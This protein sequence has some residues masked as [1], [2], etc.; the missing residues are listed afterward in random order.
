MWKIVILFIFLYSPMHAQS[1]S[2]ETYLSHAQQGDAASM[3]YVGTCLI[4]GRGVAKDEKQ[5]FEWCYKA[6]Q[7]DNIDGM[8]QVGWCYTSGTGV[9]KNKKL[10]FEYSLKAAQKGQ[11]VAQYNT[12]INYF[13]GNG[14]EINEQLGFEWCLKSA[15]N[16]YAVAE[17]HIGYCYTTGTGVAKDEKQ[18]F[19]WFV[20]ASKHGD[21]VA[22]YNLARIYNAGTLVEL[23]TEVAFNWFLKSAEQ[24]YA[25]SQGQVGY[26]YYNGI[27]VPKNLDEAFKWFMKAS[28]NGNVQAMKSLGAC[29]Y[30]GEGVA[31]N[32]E[33]GFRWYLEAANMGD[34]EAMGAVCRCYLNGDGVSKN[35]QKGFEWGLKAAEGSCAFA[36]FIVGNCY[37]D[38]QGTQQDYKKAFYWYEKAAEQNLLDA[39]NALAY[40]YIQGSGINKDEAKA[41]EMINK[42]IELDPNNLN[43]K[44]TKGELYSIVG[45]KEKALAMLDE[46][47]KT[48]PSF[49]K[50]ANSQLYQYA[51][52]VR[53]V[54]NVDID[55]PE[56]DTKAPNTFAVIIAN[57][58][59]K[60]VASVPFALND[61]E[62][63]AEYCQKTLGISEQNIHL[64]KDATLND[65]KFNI[66]WLQNVLKAYNGEASVIFYYAGHGIPDEQSKTAFILPVDGY[67][68]DVS[69]GYSLIDLYKAL[70]E[71]PSKKISVF[72]DACFSGVKRDGGM[73]ASAR[74]V[75]IKVKKT[76]PKGNMV[77]FSAA[78]NDETAYPYKEQKHGLFTYNLLKK[79]QETKGEVTLGDLSDF[80]KKQVER[81]SVVTNG[82]LQSPSVIGSSVG[83]DDWRL[84]KLK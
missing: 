57:E 19:D 60:R 45:E 25:L 81:Q 34:Y 54:N 50:N 62:I 18:G 48:D 42:A 29:Y 2:F 77:I 84:W 71:L 35:E 56:T 67:G 41:F 72:L 33:E 74:G 40:F 65:L 21:E 58:N 30:N 49:F 51:K 13:Y 12:G 8:T 1:Q 31:V 76:Q 22:Q 27:G 15:M 26:R 10:G 4:N 37:R 44:D 38:G 20:K 66:K 14:T 61:G 24:G 7:K 3:Y 80:K 5:G 17:N 55:I 78:Q 75:A 36:Q 63:F 11:S 52:K 83:N 64:V 39:Y 79:I 47:S 9:V 59:Y 70:G 73:L 28:K 23:N 43:Y 6:A 32:T 69:T 82:K 46:I 53:G 68:T 16:N